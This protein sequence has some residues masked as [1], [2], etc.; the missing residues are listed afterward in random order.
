MATQQTTLNGKVLRVVYYIFVLLQWLHR[1]P[2]TFNR[3]SNT[4]FN[5]L[6]QSALFILKIKF[7]EKVNIRLPD[8]IHES[9]AKYT[10]QFKLLTQKGRGLKQNSKRDKL[11][12]TKTQSSIYRY[13]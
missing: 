6:V 11:V 7:Y 13:I 9:I 12:Q 3:L 1:Q 10:A 5:N 2:R 4:C 8:K